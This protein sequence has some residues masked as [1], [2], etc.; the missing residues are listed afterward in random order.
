MSAPYAA[1]FAG[2]GGALTEPWLGALRGW[3]PVEALV[4][5]LASRAGVRALTRAQGAVLQRTLVGVALGAWNAAR[6]AGLPE[7]AVTL[8]HSLG[9]IAAYCASGALTDA[10]ALDV[11][12]TR[13]AAMERCALANPGGM[14]AFTRTTRE[15]VD[16]LLAAAR[17]AGPASIAAHN[18]PDEWVL[19][20]SPEALR[21]ALARS[22]GTR[23]E[24]SGPWHTPAME[25]AS[26]ELASAL[27]AV[28]ERPLCVPWVSSITAARVRTSS[29]AR[30]CLVHALTEPVR[31]VD[32]LQ[33]ARAHGARAFV[34]FGAGRALRT[35][36]RRVFGN[37]ALVHLIDEPAGVPAALRSLRGG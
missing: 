35:S 36:V 29:E 14:V 23:L 32:A 11:A 34:V 12:S 30:A 3:A 7:P 6:D 17:S 16:A 19:S 25:P 31:W 1:L 37:D 9:E 5:E 2:Q 13:G 20:G 24:V 4:P 26:G 15:A 33:T 28:P 27:A 8:G 10:E 18:A 22:R 21:A